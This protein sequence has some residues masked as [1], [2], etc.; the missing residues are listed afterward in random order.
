MHPRLYYSIR[1]GLALIFV[2]AVIAVAPASGVRGQVTGQPSDAGMICV[3][4]ADNVFNFATTDGYINLPDGNTVYM[5]GFALDVDA[6]GDGR[7]DF[8]HPGPNLCVAQASAVTINLRNTLPEAVS[9]I[10]PGQ[11]NV[12]ADGNPAQPQPAQNSLAQVAGANG[13]TIT[14]SFVADQPGT[15]LYESGTNLQKQV[16]MGLFGS[17]VVRPSAG[18]NFVYNSVRPVNPTRF[19][20]N[21]EYMMLLSEID[22]DLH[23]AVER[24]VADAAAGGPYDA[25]P[26]PITDY[27]PRYWLINGRAFPDTIAPNFASWLPTQP[28]GALLHIFP[29]S[30]GSF[31][32]AMRFL[33]VGM[34][35]HPIHP[36]G[37]H[38]RIIG[39]DGRGLES[40]AGD[41]L[42]FEKFDINVGPGQTWDALYDWTNVDNWSPGNPLPPDTLNEQART[43]INPREQNQ[44]FMDPNWYSGSPYLGYRADQDGG[45]TS[46]NECG[47][48]YHIW[49]SHALNEAANYEAGFGGMITL[50]RI[51]PPLPNTCTTQ[52]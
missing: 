15:F 8:Q 23:A 43:W 46:F 41:D 29:T 16:Q 34:L 20:Q 5:W 2:A 13:G 1:A 51:D 30:A 42:S 36:H 47:E 21:D 25:N 35:Q 50:E 6:D 44:I 3:T 33:N 18:A 11:S 12:L 24:A 10:F 26:Y 22:P 4:S 45:P 9:I 14:Y 31:P 28:Y 40:P 52:P 38:V 48:F 49:H 37:D 7:P 27:H 19:N 17:L 39:R 32:A